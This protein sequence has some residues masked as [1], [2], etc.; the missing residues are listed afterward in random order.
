MFTIEQINQLVNAGY[1]LDDILAVNSPEPVPAPTPEPVPA[2]TPEPVPAPTPEPVNTSNG[3][4]LNAI[5]NLASIIQNNNIR[6]GGFPSPT[7]VND[8]DNI[9]ASIIN[10]PSKTKK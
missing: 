3:D 8:P 10:P 1:K 9:L 7:N 4:I 5:N 2:H 6:M